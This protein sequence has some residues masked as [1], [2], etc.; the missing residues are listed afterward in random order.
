MVRIANEQCGYLTRPLFD[1]RVL[2]I[3]GRFVSKRLGVDFRF[4][5][6]DLCGP[7]ERLLHYS[8][9]RRMP[10]FVYFRHAIRKGK[11]TGIDRAREMAQHASRALHTINL[12]DDKH[13]CVQAI[14]VRGQRNQDDIL[15]SD[16]SVL[17]D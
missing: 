10:T 5:Q 11:L 7:I 9:L 3:P 14:V 8:L 15:V 1:G 17:H 12:P 2:S 13:S 6:P 16:L 4:G